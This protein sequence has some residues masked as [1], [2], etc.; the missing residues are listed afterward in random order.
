LHA[1]LL[2]DHQNCVRHGV[3]QVL[4]RQQRR[5]S[6]TLELERLAKDPSKHVDQRSLLENI[7][8][9]LYHLIEYLSVTLPRQM[10]CAVVVDIVR[11]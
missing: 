8:N 4:E 9:D 10:E 5:L 1:F 2:S 7:V 11:S 3:E 6:C